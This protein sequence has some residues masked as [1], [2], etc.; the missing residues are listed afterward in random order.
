MSRLSEDVRGRVAAVPL[1]PTVMAKAPV[2]PR[3]F[4]TLVVARGLSLVV[5]STA[6]GHTSYGEMRHMCPLALHR[7]DVYLDSKDAACELPDGTLPGQTP[8]PLTVL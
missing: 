5:C 7:L 2:P 6:E 1:A 8:R 4:D 3:R